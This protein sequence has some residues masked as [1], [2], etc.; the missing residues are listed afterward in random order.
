LIA[1]KAH[2]RDECDLAGA[3]SPAA[4][5][6]LVQQSVARSCEAYRTSLAAA[7]AAARVFTVVAETTWGSAKLLND[8]ILQN[9]TA[10]AEAAF[11]AAEAVARAR[12]LPEAARLQGEFLQLLMDSTSEQAREF[13]DLS[14]RA[15]QHVL[16][17]MQTTASRTM[18]SGL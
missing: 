13:V 1:N 16:E 5:H 10:N 17:T 14:A 12:S 4:I 7:Q 11:S 2:N 8:K 6:A 18:R 9:L 3:C 15:A